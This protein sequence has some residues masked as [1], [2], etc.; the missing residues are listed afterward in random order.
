MTEP[1]TDLW[2]NWHVLK[3]EGEWSL[4]VNK[5]MEVALVH[6]SHY[7]HMTRPFM[8]R[9]FAV[10]GCVPG[11]VDEGYFCLDCDNDPPKEMVAA[12]ILCGQVYNPIGP[13]PYYM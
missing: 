12:M 5:D 2:F 11:G 8:T 1:D 3:S 7:H 6:H 10:R 13:G 9:P 4:R